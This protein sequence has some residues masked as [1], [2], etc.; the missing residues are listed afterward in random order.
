MR[1]K[2]ERIDFGTML[3]VKD[4]AQRLGISIWHLRDLCLRGDVASVKIGT[5]PGSRG[6]KRLIP[7]SELASWI[8]RNLRQA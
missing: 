4:A 2:N 5:R 6:G 3:T 1:T 8:S 7:E